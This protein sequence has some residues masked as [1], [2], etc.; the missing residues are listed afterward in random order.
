MVYMFL[1]CHVLISL[2]VPVLNE[3]DAIPYF[4]EKVKELRKLFLEDLSLGGGYGR[5][6]LR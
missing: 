3:E 6:S 5:N 2:I 4:Y 1:E